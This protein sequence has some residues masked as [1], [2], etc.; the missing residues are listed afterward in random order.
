MIEKILNYCIKNIFFV[1]YCVMFSIFLFLNANL[2]IKNI[3]LYA[4]LFGSGASAPV[5]SG[6]GIQGGAALVQEKIEGSNLGIAESGSLMDSIIFM[7]KYLLIFSGIIAL[8]AFLYAGFLYI[9]SFGGDVDETK[10]SMKRNWPSCRWSWSNC[11][12]GS[13]RK[14]LKW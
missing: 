13:N 2:E 14:G 3:V 12:N 1:L 5:F 9:T 6:E 10:N 7:I 8:I 4:D 11:R